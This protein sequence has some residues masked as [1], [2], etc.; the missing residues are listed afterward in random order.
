LV[1]RA[2]RDRPLLESHL[3][4]VASDRAGDAE[5]LALATLEGTRAVPASIQM[6]APGETADIR[7]R[8]LVAL[9][10]PAT[11]RKVLQGQHRV[12]IDVH[13]A[14]AMTASPRVLSR[15]VVSSNGFTVV[16]DSDR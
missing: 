3:E 10:Y 7:A 4:L 6:L 11:R 12:T 8:A 16:L 1:R 5:L 13:G 2:T 15:E 9:D 14:F